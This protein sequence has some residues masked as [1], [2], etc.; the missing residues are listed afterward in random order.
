MASQKKTAAAEATKATAQ[1]NDAIRIAGLRI[2][3]KPAATIAP[4]PGRW[5][6]TRGV[7]ALGDAAIRKAIEAIRAFDRFDEDNDPYG[8]R[9]FGAVEIEGRRIFWKIDVFESEA[10]DY[11]AAHPDDPARSYRILTVMRA[12]EY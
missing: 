11:G 5:M 3:P 6:L 7:A 2:G 4:P 9:D 12:E 8:L 10:C 1:L